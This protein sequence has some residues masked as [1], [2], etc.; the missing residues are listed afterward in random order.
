[1]A[2]FRQKDFSSP[3]PSYADMDVYLNISENGT[4]WN[5]NNKINLTS[6]VAEKFRCAYD[7]DIFFDFNDVLHIAFSTIGAN[8]DYVHPESTRFDP[9][10]LFIWHWS[11]ATDSF[12]V[13]VDGWWPDPPEG[14]QP[15]PPQIDCQMG[16]RHIVN[17]AQ[18]AGDPSTGNL[19][20]VY[21]RNSYFDCT[22]SGLYPNTELWATVSTDGGLNWS[23]GISITNTPTPG[24]IPCSCATEIQP[25][26][27]DFVNDTL[28]LLYIY[29]RDSS[30]RG[31]WYEGGMCES[32]VIYQRVPAS[33]IPTT[34]LIPQFSIQEGPI[35][36]RYLPGDLN[37]D[38]H[39]Y[40]NDV[41]YAVNYLKGPGMPPIVDCD[42]PEV[43]RPFY[44]AGDVNGSC[45]FNGLDVTYYVLY[46]KG[47]R[48]PRYCPSCPPSNI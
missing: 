12:T 28:H 43:Y 23:E 8:F 24:C 39:R 27:D 20:M 41:T 9:Y 34:P 44:A 6:F 19:Y 7:L 13:A 33:L 38:G 22:Y 18:L 17:N 46:F 5:W 25:S 40:G 4:D 42:C 2:Y 11:E 10:L 14:W 15:P 45:T 31:L 16:N 21:E 1:M 37:G 48:W 26:L 36:C 3:P 47:I 29:D 35:R 32:E 30:I